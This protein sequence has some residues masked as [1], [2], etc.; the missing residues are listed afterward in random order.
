MPTHE[1]HV[2]FTKN[3]ALR[4]ASK[5]RLYPSNLVKIILATSDL[6]MVRQRRWNYQF[7]QRPRHQ[8]QSLDSDGLPTTSAST[9]T[10]QKTGLPCSSTSTPQ[11]SPATLTPSPSPEPMAPRLSPTS[12]AKIPPQETTSSSPGSPQP[13]SMRLPSLPSAKPPSTNSNWWATPSQNLRP[14]PRHLRTSAPPQ[15][16]DTSKRPKPNSLFCLMTE[17]GFALKGKSASFPN[18]A[19]SPLSFH[20]SY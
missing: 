18:D 19:S 4:K 16:I 20:R 10:F 2:R 6:F 7:R 9:P 5:L 15:P 14:A 11:A 17:W 3:T 12:T 13:V 1:P 8:P